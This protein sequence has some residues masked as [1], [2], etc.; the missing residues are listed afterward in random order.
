MINMNIKMPLV[1]TIPIINIM[2]CHYMTK[3]FEGCE[4]KE[5]IYI[6]SMSCPQQLN[7]YDCILYSIY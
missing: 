1:F 5:D 4:N 3:V 2:L 6:Y 7:G